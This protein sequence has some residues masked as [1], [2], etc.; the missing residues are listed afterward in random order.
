[1][2][3]QSDFSGR[4]GV[5]SLIRILSVVFLLVGLLVTGSPAAAHDN[6]RGKNNE[7]HKKPNACGET[8][9]A[10]LTACRNSATSDYWL[11]IGNCD[12]ISDRHDKQDCL[13]EAQSSLKEDFKACKEQFQARQDVCKDLGPDPY[14]PDISQIEWVTPL[15][16]NYFPLD[17]GSKYTYE[18]KDSDGNIQTIVVTVGGTTTIDDVECRIVTDKVWE[19]TDTSP[20]TGRLLEDTID[21]YAQDL[22]GNVW[23]FGETT[24]AYTYDDYGNPT[25]STEGSWMAGMDE[26]KPGII[27]LADPGNQ[28]GKLYRQEFALGTAEDLGKVIGVNESVTAEGAAYTG[29]VHTQDSTPLEPDVIENKWYAPNVGLVLTIEPEAT[30]ELITEP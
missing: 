25:A 24:I 2:K 13:A 22:D 29:C 20:D 28:I 14:D 21:W 23:Y 26:A 19:G 27:M 5:G 30:E 6:D 1:M 15:G 12:N 7:K 11:G 18:S 4:A 9:K 16:N 3:I 17:P 10:A 8:S